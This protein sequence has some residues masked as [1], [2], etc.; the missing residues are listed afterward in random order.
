[1]GRLRRNYAETG[2]F[3]RTVGRAG[4]G[5]HSPQGQ[6]TSGSG[7]SNPSFATCGHE[8][9]CSKISSLPQ[10]CY[11]FMTCDARTR[12]VR[13]RSE[14]R[15]RE[16]AHGV[17]RAAPRTNANGA[18]GAVRRAGTRAGFLVKLNLESTL[19][20]S[21][22]PNKSVIFNQSALC[23]FPRFLAYLAIFVRQEPDGVR[24]GA[25][26]RKKTFF[27]ENK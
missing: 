24:L 20:V 6:L 10:I 11:R 9:P 21:T 12:T 26:S 8:H 5:L 22:R 7:H 14:K 27:I 17:Q 13:L 19:P 15:S 3:P 25:E 1:M 4:S 18:S 2:C 16:A 23:S